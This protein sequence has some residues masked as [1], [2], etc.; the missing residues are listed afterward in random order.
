[1][2]TAEQESASPHLSG[3]EIAERLD[4]LQELGMLA[5]ELSDY[6]R[7][8]ERMLNWAAQEMRR[9]QRIAQPEQILPEVIGQSF[10][11]QRRKDL[12]T[13]AEI[14]EELGISRT[15]LYF[16]RKRNTFPKP[17]RVSA[18]KVAFRRKEVEI[19]LEAS[20]DGPAPLGQPVR[21]AG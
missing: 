8:T 20:K 13:I 7:D 3:G 17:V 16:M 14:T 6:L 4:A 19:W 15:T 18:S 9:S 1:M 12:V 11:G 2:K 10:R 21:A 5:R